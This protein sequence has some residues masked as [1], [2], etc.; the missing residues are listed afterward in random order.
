CPPRPNV[1]STYTPS[2]T[3]CAGGA[4]VQR[5][6]SNDGSTRAATVG[7]SST[8]RCT[9]VM[10]YS[11][12]KCFEYFCGA[13]RQILGLAAFQFLGVPQFKM[14]RHAQQ[15][16]VAL[17]AHCGAQFGSNQYP[18]GGIQIDVLS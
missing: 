18:A 11:E 10:T 13:C 7:S 2:S 15:H 5:R 6:A 1:Q 9:S 8:D 4:C 12:R 14:G 3:P 16:G 17:Q